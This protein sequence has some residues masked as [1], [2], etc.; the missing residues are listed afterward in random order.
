[1]SKV[2]SNNRDLILLMVDATVYIEQSWKI[3]CTDIFDY[4]EMVRGFEK[5]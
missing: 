3:I 5:G 4:H 1:M 2:D